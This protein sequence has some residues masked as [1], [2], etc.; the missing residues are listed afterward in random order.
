MVDVLD[1]EI[2]LVAVMLGIA[3]SF[4]SP[5]G[6]VMMEAPKREEATENNS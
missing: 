1:G 6:F 2:K 3:P 4:H 5:A